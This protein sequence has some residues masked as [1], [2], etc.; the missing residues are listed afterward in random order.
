MIYACIYSPTRTDADELFSNENR[1]IASINHDD[2]LQ[3]DILNSYQT[4]I[5]LSTYVQTHNQTTCIKFT[6]HSLVPIATCDL[7]LCWN[8]PM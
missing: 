6:A 3:T 8:L 5:N 2:Q 1:N 4:W 7:V